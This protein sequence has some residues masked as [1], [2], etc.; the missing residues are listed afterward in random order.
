MIKIISFIKTFIKFFKFFNKIKI[1]DFYYKNL[2]FYY[3]F[4]L[5]FIKKFSYNN[6]F[7]KKKFILY[8]FFILLKFFFK[9]SFFENSKISF[10]NNINI[11]NTK[12]GFS[13]LVF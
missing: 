7:F 11:K 8:F 12:F 4:F 6:F 1:L 13:I 10:F 3:F 9:F 5:D 2:Y